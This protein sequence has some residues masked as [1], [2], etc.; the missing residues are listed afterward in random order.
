MIF[1]VILNVCNCV[2]VCFF[3]SAVDTG[4]PCLMSLLTIP[5][6]KS[7][8]LKYLKLMKGEG[9]SLCP[10]L[11]YWLRIMN[12]FGSADASGIVLAS[13]APTLFFPYLFSTQRVSWRLFVFIL[14]YFSVCSLVPN[15]L[16]YG[17]VYCNV[18]FS[19]GSAQWHHTRAILK[20]HMQK[21]TK[22]L[23]LIVTK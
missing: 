6:E 19:S 9:N 18:R 11:Q 22:N 21:K 7:V 20:I 4:V 13:P 2:C 15:I 8:Q 10:K 23:S 14:R 5:W 12:T 16:I 17:L 1:I 3:K